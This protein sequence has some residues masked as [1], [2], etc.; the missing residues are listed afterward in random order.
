MTT[1]CDLPED[2]LVELLSLLPARDLL[3]TCRVV[4]RQWRYVV[5]LATLW[6]RKCQREGFYRQNLDGS[7]SDWKV[8]YMLCHLKRNLIKN[9]CAE[10]KF[11][12]WK[13][14]NNEGDKWKI[15][16][17]PGPHGRD[18]ADPK[19]QKYFVTSYGPCFKSQLITLQKEGYWNQLMDEK[20]PEIV[21]KDWYAARFDCGCRY[22][23]TVRLLSEDYIVLAEFRP[24][25]VVI[26]QWND[27]AWREISHTFQ[28]YPPGVR[29]IWFQHGG[30]DTQFWAGW[31]GIRVTNSSITIG[32]LTM[33]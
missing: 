15:E 33:L 20:R 26:E 27:A 23:L 30:Q 14:D 2:V 5:D 1:I 21:V 3:R 29:Y 18:I 25:P 28:N 9:P 19:V 17:M 32:P 11:Q 7:V 10:E 4:C 13:L 6:K 16:N 22:E 8:F 31:Y 24:E 12:H